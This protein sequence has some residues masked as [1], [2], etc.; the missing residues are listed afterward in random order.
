MEKK[1]FSMDLFPDWRTCPFPRAVQLDVETGELRVTRCWQNR[2]PACGPLKAYFLSKPLASCPVMLTLTQTGSTWPELRSSMAMVHRV[3]RRR[4]RALGLECATAWVV[5]QD[6]G[7][8]GDTHV[9]S[10]LNGPLPE[11][12]GLQEMVSDAAAAA[13]IGPRAHLRWCHRPRRA[14]GLYA[15]SPIVDEQSLLHHVDIN[16]GQ[17]VRSVGPFW[18][19][20][21][22]QKAYLRRRQP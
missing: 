3:L 14:W 1:S 15:F 19:G 5:H 16:G 18:P 10:W 9:H 4:F 6:P 2:C 22:G 11:K 12:M 20:V 8:D 7:G 21:H 17:L 13:G